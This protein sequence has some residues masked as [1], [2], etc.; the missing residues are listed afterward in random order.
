MARRLFVDTSGWYALV[1][2]RDA[3]HQAAREQV[4]A[5]I[6]SGGRLVT[7]DY[8]VDESCTLTKARAGSPASLRLL[9]LLRQSEGVDWEWVTT[10]R[11]ARAETIFRRQ[12]DQGYSFT[13]CTSFAIMR[14]ARLDR[15]LTSDEHFQRAG[16]VASLRDAQAR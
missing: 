5:H 11:F 7:T 13:D 8:V 3:W 16:F 9:D 12:H 2:R 15:A 14:E 4:D 1:D 6:A 10:E